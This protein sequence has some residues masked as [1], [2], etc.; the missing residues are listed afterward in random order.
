MGSHL[1]RQ[2]YRRPHARRPC[3]TNSRQPRFVRRGQ[4]TA[5]GVPFCVAPRA[6]R[7]ATSD[8]PAGF[9]AYAGAEGHGFFYR[10]FSLAMRWVCGQPGPKP[11]S[12][13]WLGTVCMTMVFLRPGSIVTVLV[14][15]AVWGR[16]DR[17]FWFRSNPSPASREPPCP[18]P[19]PTG[20]VVHRSSRATRSTW[21][22]A[23]R[24]PGRCGSRGSSLVCGPHFPCMHKARDWS[25]SASLAPC[26]TS[27]HTGVR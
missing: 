11:C 21:S 17:I 5:A 24:V 20:P 14:S 18:G 26:V 22:Q 3:G 27:H 15:E 13:P 12:S 23:S 25:R 16:Y 8:G 2:D 9:L 1:H 6:R 4:P 7:V 19:Q 10:R